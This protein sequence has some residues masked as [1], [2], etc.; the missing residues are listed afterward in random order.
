MS[1]LENDILQRVISGDHG[2]YTWIAA[3]L[4][5]LVRGALTEAV[6]RGSESI[7]LSDPRTSLRT[8]AGPAG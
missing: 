6:Q 7:E 8:E 3:A 2:G 4:M 5:T 1:L